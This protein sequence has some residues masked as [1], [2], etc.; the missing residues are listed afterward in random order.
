MESV[1][2]KQASPLDN[3]RVASPCNAE[4]NKMHG[5]DHVR[6]CGECKLSVY[7]ISAMSRHE[8]ESLLAGTGGRLCVRYY[9]RADGTLISQDCPTGLRA[10]RA[11]MH[12][13]IR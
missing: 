8:A 6:F 9:K 3:L 4:W 13:S 12:R 7:N 1:M 2:N 5:N 10:V 11:K